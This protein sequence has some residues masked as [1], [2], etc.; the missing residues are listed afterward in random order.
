[1]SLPQTNKELVDYAASLSKAGASGLGIEL[2]RRFTTIPDA[3]TS[4]CDPLGL[5]RIVLHRP[6]EF[7]Q[8][9]E[10]VH[11]EILTERMLAIQLSERAH[12]AFT[13]VAVDGATV[14][15]V[16]Q[17]A[18][19]MIKVLVVLEDVSRRVLPSMPL[20]PRSMLC[21]SMFESGQA[22]YLPATALPQLDACPKPP[23]L[24]GRICSWRYGITSS[25]V[26]IHQR[27]RP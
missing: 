5:P 12:I 21:S 16:V 3:F 26:S 23:K 13:A 11:S 1:M 9:T 19:K 6:V 4:A 22:R 15:E 17:S 24:S 14:A 7:A 10:A 20:A 27:R 2:G 8:I 18:A 25:T